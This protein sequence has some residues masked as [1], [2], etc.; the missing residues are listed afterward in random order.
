[1]AVECMLRVA[2]KCASIDGAARE[3]PSGYFYG[4]ARN[5][6][7]EWWRLETRDTKGRGLLREE[8]AR[9]GPEDGRL[10]SRKETVH[11]C[12]DRCMG[13]LTPR[14][15]HAAL[16]Y[17]SEQGEARSECHRKLAG[18]LGKSMNAL[19][20]EVHRIRAV[21]RQ[22]VLACLRSDPPGALDPLEPG[23]DA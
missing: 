7:H 13:R 22:C 18:E 2:G 14:A 16:A 12:L 19:R 5:V 15:R 10:W 1:M 17:Y 6:L 11:L 4:V 20:I 3:S 9:A 21:L 8:L 23:P